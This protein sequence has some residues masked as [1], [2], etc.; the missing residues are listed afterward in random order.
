MNSR[1]SWTANLFV[2]FLIL[3]FSFNDIVNIYSL[4]STVSSE[5]G[6]QVDPN[7]AGA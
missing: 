3:T 6:S 2:A 4:V 1:T 5:D 7:G